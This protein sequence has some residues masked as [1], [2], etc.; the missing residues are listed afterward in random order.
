MEGGDPSIFFAKQL[1]H[2][3]IKI[4]ESQGKDGIRVDP[5]GSY[6]LERG[7]PLELFLVLTPHP[8]EINPQQLRKYISKVRG[9]RA[10]TD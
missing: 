4:K 7:N 5:Q 10:A 9:T 2:L 1:L 6:G 8:R 3:K